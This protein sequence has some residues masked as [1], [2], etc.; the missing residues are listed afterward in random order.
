MFERASYYAVF[1]VIA[2]Y[3]HENLKFSSEQASTVSG[4]FGGWVWFLAIFGGTI[5][6]KL[7]V[8]RALALGYLI[9]SGSYFLLGSLNA[10]WLAPFRSAMPLSALVTILL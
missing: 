2:R 4:Q 3:L 1:T 8:R 10:S 6:D 9:L 5:A 7:G